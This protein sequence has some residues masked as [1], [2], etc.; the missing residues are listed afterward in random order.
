MAKNIDP[1]ELAPEGMYSGKAAHTPGPWH[2]FTAQIHDNARRVIARLPI[3]DNCAPLAERAGNA[4]LMAESPAMLAQLRGWLA[5][6]DREAAYRSPLVNTAVLATKAIL[7]RVDG[8][9]IAKAEGEA[10]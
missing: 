10:S 6:F 1:D 5:I 9:A 2:H 3:G 7:A 8:A 4:R